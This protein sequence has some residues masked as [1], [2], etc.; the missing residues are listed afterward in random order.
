MYMRC[1]GVERIHTRAVVVQGT[2]I[3]KKMVFK[4]SNSVV[5][6]KKMKVRGPKDRYACVEKFRVIIDVA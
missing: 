3:F 6:W 1:S 5:L 4:K 2:Y